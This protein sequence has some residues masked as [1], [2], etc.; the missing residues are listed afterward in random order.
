MRAPAQIFVTAK[1]VT[2]YPPT[3]DIRCRMI[4]KKPQVKSATVQAGANNQR[5][6]SDVDLDLLRTSITEE[7]LHSLRINDAD[8]AGMAPS[9][10]E[11]L[12]M[13]DKEWAGLRLSPK[14]LLLLREDLTRRLGVSAQDLTWL[15]R[16]I[17]RGQHGHTRAQT[18][19]H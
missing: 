16:A 9:V 13:T 2:P 3:G 11:I 4:R 10:E 1:F 8:L 12:A 19:T 14:A 7:D 15:S 5:H 6:R 17:E 18:G